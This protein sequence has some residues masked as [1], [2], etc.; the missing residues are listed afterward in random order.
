MRTLNNLHLLKGIKYNNFIILQHS[1]FKFSASLETKLVMSV[2]DVRC[3]NQIC[4]SPS[5]APGR[6]G[7]NAAICNLLFE[8]IMNP[9]PSTVFG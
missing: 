6:T 9:S 2:C 1:E 7:T 8:F 4:D 5:F 3:V